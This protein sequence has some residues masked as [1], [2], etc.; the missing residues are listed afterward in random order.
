MK[1]CALTRWSSVGS[2]DEPR[3]AE[4]EKET[5]GGDRE[6]WETEWSSKLNS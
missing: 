1:T 3:V 5:D 4:V 2:R 6:V